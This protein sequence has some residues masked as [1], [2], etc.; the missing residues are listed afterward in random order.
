MNRRVRIFL[1]GG[2]AISLI[3]LCLF[4]FFY[5]PAK[6]L[7]VDFLNVGQG[8]AELIKTPY[9]QNILIDG[10]PDNKVLAELGRNLPFLERKID[11]VINTHPHDDHVSGLI[12]VLNKYQ[13]QRI[14]MTAAPSNAPPFAEFLKT[15]AAKKTP[16][17]ILAG[18]EEITLGPDL[19]LQILYPGKND[20]LGSDLNEDSIVAKLIYKNEEFLFTGDAGNIT[21]AKLLAEKI[22]L[23]AD[24]LKVGH[25][26]SET[27]SGLDFLRAVSPQIAV[28]ECGA[29]NQFGFPKP[30]TLWRLNKIG[31]RIFRTDLNGTVKIKTDGAR[32]E[33]KSNK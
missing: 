14:L 1:I 26:G 24:V 22:D 13:V 25:H 4:L 15:V 17:I 6:F 11:L 29:N 32:I 5:H 31:A 28:I 2:A 18:Q 30:D 20:A 12:D 23:K 19:I 16:V 27:A 33:V 8:D 21:E 3:G 10:G 7:E 9:G